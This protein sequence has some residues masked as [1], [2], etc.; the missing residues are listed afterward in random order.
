M[1]ERAIGMIFHVV[2]SFS[3]RFFL[4]PACVLVDWQWQRFFLY[5]KRA[6]LFILFIGFLHNSQSYEKYFFITDCHK[7]ESPWKVLTLHQRKQTLQDLMEFV[8]NFPFLLCGVEADLIVER[9][10]NRKFCINPRSS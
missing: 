4:N 1:G 2:T 7:A 3:V 6:D 9:K 8:M 10:K 5:L